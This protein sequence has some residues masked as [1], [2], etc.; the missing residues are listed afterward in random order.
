VA[1]ASR[2]LAATGTVPGLPDL[3]LATLA[4]NRY[5]RAVAGARESS[6][7]RRCQALL[8][9]RGAWQFKTQSGGFGGVVG[10]P[11]LIAVHRGLFLGVEVK[12]PEGGRLSDRQAAVGAAIRRA[13]GLWCVVTDPKQLEEVLD[14]MDTLG[15]VKSDSPTPKI[16][17]QEP[18]A[19]AVR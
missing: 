2:T 3:A 12:R 17:T 11:D 4:W 19:G 16:L 15:K 8:K 14:W 1:G 6:N 13:G 18:K 7:V 9:R 5:G 10:L